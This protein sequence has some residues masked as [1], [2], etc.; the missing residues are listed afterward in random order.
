MFPT[1]ASCTG[2]RQGRITPCNTTKPDSIELRIRTMQLLLASKYVLHNIT[3][4]SQPNT[5]LNTAPPPLPLPLLS[6]V[7]LYPSSPH[8]ACELLGRRSGKGPRLPHRLPRRAHL[9]PQRRSDGGATHGRHAQREP[10]ARRLPSLV[11]LH[12]RIPPPAAPLL[13]SAA[14]RS[15]VAAAAA[16]AAAAAAAA[17]VAGPGG[18]P[19]AT[20]LLCAASARGRA[21]V[22]VPRV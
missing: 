13:S 4:P 8:L 3:F 14:A 11:P 15:P 12:G 2:L 9:P 19:R 6:S 22:R 5:L 7:Y 21:A 1:G 18:S 16:T 20:L 10:S 17:I